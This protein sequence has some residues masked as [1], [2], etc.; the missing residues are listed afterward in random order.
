MVP[1]FY[2]LAYSQLPGLQELGLLLLLHL[3][4]EAACRQKT[5]SQL[6]SASRPSLGVGSIKVSFKLRNSVR[7]TPCVVFDKNRTGDPATGHLGLRKS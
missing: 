7:Y 6:A 3:A 4:E 5:S 1:Y 2:V